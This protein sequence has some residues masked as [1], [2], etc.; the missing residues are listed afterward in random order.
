MEITGLKKQYKNI[1]SPLFFPYMCGHEAT[2]YPQKPNEKILHNQKYKIAA[3]LFFLLDY[4]DVYKKEYYNYPLVQYPKG[5]R[6]DS[7]QKIKEKI[8]GNIFM[9]L[10]SLIRLKII[11]CLF[12]INRIIKD[13]IIFCFKNS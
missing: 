8:R 9:L 4:G 12:A 7:H 3:D 10:K 6:S 2:I 5:G 11:P 13:V 1:P